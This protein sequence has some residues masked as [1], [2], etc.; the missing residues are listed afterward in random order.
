MASK[1]SRPAGPQ[2][3]PTPTPAFPPYQILSA[4][5]IPAL[6]CQRLRVLG[7]AGFR[8]SGGPCLTPPL[9]PARLLKQDG[10]R[11]ER[12]ARAEVRNRRL[13]YYNRHAGRG[14][15]SLE[16]MR[17]RDPLLW[18]HHIGRYQG[19]GA[20]GPHMP[21]GGGSMSEMLLQQHDEVQLRLRL[22][23]GAAA[24]ARQ[25]AMV[26]EET[27]SD[28][29]TEEPGRAAA[30]GEPSGT[31][32]L[33][34]AG[35]AFGGMDDVQGVDYA[36][37]H[38]SEADRAALQE[39][40]IEEMKMRFLDGG[41]AGAFDYAAVDSDIGLDEDWAAAEEQDAQDRYF[42]ESD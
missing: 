28:E 11:S 12:T 21:E 37:A 36:P 22:H 14:F 31:A 32:A 3:T 34:N 16:A 19:A 8:D 29:E 17:D 9:P 39:D 25:A 1:Q 30:G 13:A 10:E 33:G 6:L 38:A 18:Q 41:D 35:G 27:D 40:F 2:H 23:A 7:L 4:R 5:G 42:D 15:F 24:E 20:S 26:E